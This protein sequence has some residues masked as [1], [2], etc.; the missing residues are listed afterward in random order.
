MKT[1][2]LRTRG[3]LLVRWLDAYA[4]C[5]DCT[6]LPVDVDDHSTGGLCPEHLDSFGA[7]QLADQVNLIRVGIVHL[8]TGAEEGPDGA[9]LALVEADE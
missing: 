9:A 8:I 5:E 2:D 3:T 7:L 6:I 4:D 1:P